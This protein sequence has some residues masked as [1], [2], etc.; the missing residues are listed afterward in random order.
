MEQTPKLVVGIVVD[1]MRWDY[2]T[3][4][5]DR[6]TEGGFRR[7]MSEGYN[8]NR[9][10]INYLPAVTA[11]GHTSLYTGTVPAFSG[12][13]GNYQYFDGKWMSPVRDYSVK[14]LGTDSKEG[15]ASPHRVLCTT[16]TDELRLATNFRS[17]VVSVCI[18]DRGA[19][20]PGGHCAS[21]A[22]WMDSENLCWVSSTY[23]MKELPKWVKDFNAK[24]IGKQYLKLI[25]TDKKDKDNYWDLL[26]D[27][28]SYVQSTP[29]LKED[30]YMTVGETLKESPWGNTY[31]ADMALQAL[32]KEQLGKNPAGVPDYLCVSFSCTDIIG[33][34]V[35]PNAP[36]MEDV[37]LR[38][39]KDIKR[40]L[41]TLDRQMGKD[42][43]VVWL[44]AD[45]AGSHNVVFRQQHGIPAG[46]WPC[47]RIETDLNRMLNDEFGTG[48]RL[49]HRI[50]DYQV[51][52]KQE[53]IDSTFAA[54]RAQSP[55]TVPESA[56]ALKLQI[57]NRI[58]EIVEKWDNVAYAFEPRKIPDYV[59]E[60]VRTMAINGYNPKRSGD[61]MIIAEANITEDYDDGYTPD[62]NGI[63]KG[64][65]HGVW[66]PYDTH[67]PFIV[68]GK[69][70]RHAW[71][72]NTYHIVDIA[73]TICSILNIQQP[74]SC[75]GRAI[76]IR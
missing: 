41:D 5:Y 26:Y 2:L 31:T 65:N 62:Y 19:V 51:F 73:P 20:L 38:L 55:L 8:C 7:L 48:T 54:Q 61:V 60:P 68:M 40:I 75:T 29:N 57:I 53:V 42:N 27:K 64:T 4:Y 50:E 46:T 3:R 63:P 71:D 30:Y 35:A 43:Y 45:H 39:D 47:Y 21:A 33:H 15:Q 34:N 11:V 9:V 16:M 37:Y 28:D 72:N 6:Y 67:I 74:S 44:S 10:L 56:K 13:I 23:Y 49:V 69:G 32:D 66:S 22:Y 17:K 12:I 18:K 25:T 24:D 1:Q 58:I 36:W 70:V 59:P 52:L 14:A 76:D